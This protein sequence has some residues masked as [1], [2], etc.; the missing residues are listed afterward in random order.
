MKFKLFFFLLIYSSKILAQD[1][2][3]KGLLYQ[4]V[5][6]EKVSEK[7]LENVRCPVVLLDS[8]SI[9]SMKYFQMFPLQKKIQ[10]KF[11]SID[12]FTPDYI[13]D[14]EK[15]LT[16]VEFYV[17]GKK[18]Y[19]FFRG[20]SSYYLLV[21]NNEHAEEVF[22]AIYC[23]NFK[24]GILKSAVMLAENVKSPHYSE[25]SSFF[26]SEKKELIVLEFSYILYFHSKG[27]KSKAYGKINHE[28]FFELLME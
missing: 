28:G 26:L 12:L 13:H 17:I 21:S 27:Y 3:D 14:V 24:E 2:T 18:K 5:F 20:I 15:Q 7:E 10:K 8:F 22:N 11:L 23:L 6:N 19:N 25:Q 4:N 16:S 9:Q 1:W